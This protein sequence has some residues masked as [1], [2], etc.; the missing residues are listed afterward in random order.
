MREEIYADQPAFF[1]VMDRCFRERR[2]IRTETEFLYRITGKRTWVAA[3]FGFVPPDLVMVSVDDITDRKDKEQEIQRLN[4]ELEQRVRDRTREL[5]VSE[6]RLADA[7]QLAHIGSWEYDA[8]SRT[9]LR[10]AE[11]CRML[12]LPPDSANRFSPLSFDR[13]HPDDRDLLESNIRTALE[14][15]GSSSV[16]LRV[17][18]L[19]G[20]ERIVQVHSQAVIEPD[21]PVRV[22]GTMQDVTDSGRPNRLFAGEM[23]RQSQK[24]APSDATGGV[25]HDFNNLLTVIRG[26]AGLIERLPAPDPGQRR[27]GAIL[28]AVDRAAVLTAQLLAF[29]RKQPHQ[30]KPIDLDE[31]VGA[32]QDMLARLGGGRTK[33]VRLA[34]PGLHRIWADR[35]QVEQILINL[36]ANAC[37]AM[38]HGGPIAIETGNVRVDEPLAE[39]LGAP[40]GE[41]VKL[42]VHDKGVGMDAEVQSHIF[43]P[44]FTTKAIGEGT[45]LGLSTVKL[46]PA[47]RRP[48]RLTARRD[49]APVRHLFSAVR[50][51]RGRG[52][53]GGRAHAAG[54]G[55]RGRRNDPAR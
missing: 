37:D 42:V 19:D 4:D 23:L 38:T 22:V 49:K 54:R 47:V 11:M 17:L 46:R 1:D 21:R 8:D 15:R 2:V 51:Q 28:S 45:G 32:I 10:S 26:H 14:T 29:G 50:R 34:E 12:G 35:G 6:A 40:Q 53:G 36:V 43:E 5:E 16:E 13:V 31:A 55:S 30:P 39:R 20:Q 18:P 52:R 25:A 41:Y 24:M 33:L 27:T 7:Q 3:S 9:I 48:S 44:F